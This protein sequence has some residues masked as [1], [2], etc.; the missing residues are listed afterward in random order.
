[1]FDLIEAERKIFLHSRYPSQ[2]G[3]TDRAGGDDQVDVTYGRYR[4]SVHPA[5]RY[6]QGSAFY[7]FTPLK[8]LNAWTLD[9]AAELQV[10]SVRWHGQ[11]LNLD[12]GP[13]NLLT[14]IFPQTL[15]AGIADSLEI[16]YQG[17]PPNN[18]FGSFEVTEHAGVPVLW[19]LSEPYGARDWFPCHQDLNDKIDSCDIFITAP[20]G[21]RASSNGVLLSETTSNGFT[22]AH[23]STRYPTA[24]YL[25]CMAVTNYTVYEHEVPFGNTV[26]KVLNY[27]YPEDLSASQAE[28][29]DII[30]QMQLFDSLF[31]LYPFHLEKYGHTQFSWGGGMEHQT[32]TFV[33]NFNFELIGHELAHHWFGDKITCGSWEDIWLNEGFATYLAGL[34]YEHLRPQY[35]RQY[36][37]VRLNSVVS[38]PGG[39]VLVNDTTDV[40]RVFSGRLSYSKGALVLHQLRWM[41]GDNAF[42]AAL[43]N[44]LH[45]PALAYGYARTPDLKFHLEQAYGKDLTGYFA[46]WYAGEG[47]PSYVVL[48]SQNAS[49]ELTV[50]LDQ[51]S[52][53]P[54]SVAFF[55]MPVPVKL[56][57]T[58][59]GQDT[60][61]VLDHTFSGQSF[62]AQLSF[63]A[64]SL[65][66]DPDLWLISANNI[67]SK[68]SAVPATPD[69][70]FAGINLTP[71]PA[72]EQLTLALNAR[73]ETAFQAVL[74]GLDG[75]RLAEWALRAVPGVNR[76]PLRLNSLPAGNYQLLLQGDGWQTGRNVAVE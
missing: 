50:R 63:Q 26:T 48:W 35:W 66:F 75:K 41:L 32:M 62:S 22:T 38:K 58:S 46:D 11:H 8:P 20:A 34:C 14:L 52:S 73:R 24:A 57:N 23:W 18:G 29:P 56:Y 4:W 19:T 51:T 53:L 70:V 72:H 13:S 16:F 36:R 43:K 39:S 12:H 30:G 60:L 27:V 76:F 68:L 74:L 49:N 31:G 47:Y 9:L 59:T 65:A 1:M 42:F 3:V 2:A 6:I 44:Y 67:V 5:I 10:D 7:R 21:N 17:D 55:E 37:Q 61:L 33:V 45:D 28:S 69:P 54:S 64:D 15:A 25:L 71:N 40:Y